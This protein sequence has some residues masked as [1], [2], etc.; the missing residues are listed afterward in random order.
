MEQS[1]MTTFRL[2]MALVLAASQSGDPL[3]PADK[4]TLARLRTAISDAANQAI[5]LRRFER[6]LPQTN[7][8]Q[9]LR[10]QHRIP[11]S[12]KDYM[13]VTFMLA[14]YGRD[15]RRNL[16]YLFKPYRD[17]RRQYESP[18]STSRDEETAGEYDPNAADVEDVPY[19]LMLLYKKHHD[20]KALG[21]LLDMQTDG[22]LAEGQCDALNKLVPHEVALLRAASFSSIRL[23]NMAKM[24]RSICETPSDTRT[25]IQALRELYLK[26]PDPRV[27]TAAKRVISLLSRDLSQ[28]KRSHE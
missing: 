20:S 27:A 24:Y 19:F 15:Y 3:S 16:D 1:A 7:I 11:A 10:L 23:N 6:L 25:N 18:D 2:L 13:N 5:T 22:A 8:P 9:W 14:Y 17:W 26:H 12:R 4:A 21:H 28:K